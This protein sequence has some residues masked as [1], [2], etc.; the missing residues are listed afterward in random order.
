ME[1]NQL[2]QE[3]DLADVTQLLIMSVNR[4]AEEYDAL[5][6]KLNN[7]E[8]KIRELEAENK[9]LRE[10]AEQTG[11]AISNL[12]SQKEQ[13]LTTAKKTIAQ[14]EFEL[15][16]VNQELKAFK[17][18]FG[19][20]KKAKD[21]IA[22][23]KKSNDELNKRIDRLTKENKQYRNE[24][25]ALKKRGMELQ[26]G[27]SIVSAMESICWE[28]DGE[29][30]LLFHRQ[31]ARCEGAEFSPAL[32]Y[33]SPTGSAS[34]VTL[35]D[36]EPTLSRQPRGGHKPKAATT[37]FARSWLTKVIDQK[38]MVKADDLDALKYN[39]T[40]QSQKAA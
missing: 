30:L 31:M 9:K 1:L 40:H 14:L 36:G 37:H 39:L 15:N 38:G 22:R 20:V 12:E 3:L 29:Y 8:L 2:A 11:A 35:E 13:A 32:L 28:H 4:D 26:F 27:D 23:N 19:T 10:V 16:N 33:I 34:I 7:S 17:E 18:H 6:I 5:T 24:N 21:R 25:F